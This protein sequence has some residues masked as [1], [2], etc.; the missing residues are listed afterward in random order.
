M[1]TRAL[2]CRMSALILVVT[3]VVIRFATTRPIR[4]V[5]GP[6]AIRQGLT[7]RPKRSV[8]ECDQNGGLDQLPVSQPTN[9]TRLAHGATDGASPSLHSQ[10]LAAPLGCTS[11]GSIPSPF[12][13]YGSI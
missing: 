9:A 11:Q 12:Q 13:P 8:V 1:K 2:V 10:R 6:N 5:G 3:L 7:L 4:R